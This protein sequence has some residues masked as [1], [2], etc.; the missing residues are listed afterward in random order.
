MSLKT[1]AITLATGF[2]IESVTAA[3]PCGNPDLFTYDSREAAT[4][5]QAHALAASM[6]PADLFGEIRVTPFTTEDGCR[7][8]DHDAEFWIYRE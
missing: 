7:D 5:E 1:T 3:S 4:L 6:M 2:R 8:Y